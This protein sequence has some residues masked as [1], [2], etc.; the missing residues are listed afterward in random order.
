MYFFEYI[1]WS[2]FKVNDLMK[3]EVKVNGRLKR[4]KVK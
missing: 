3:N 2:H 1:F 4:L